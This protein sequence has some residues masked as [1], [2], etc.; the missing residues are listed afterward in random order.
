M[1]AVIIV[2]ILL[3]LYGLLLLVSA[4]F[5]KKQRGIIVSTNV[6][7]SVIVAFRNEGKH[8]ERLMKSLEKQV[9]SNLEIVLVDDHSED[10][11]CKVVKENMLSNVQLLHLPA[12]LTG[13]KQAI[14]YGVEHAKADYILITDADCLVPTSWVG[15]MVQELLTK[16]RDWQAGAIKYET[17]EGVLN[18]FQRIESAYL[19]MI[20]GWTMA[21]NKPTTCNGANIIFKKAV[22]EKE[23]GFEGLMQTPS[24]DDELLMQKL[25]S[26]GYKLGYCTSNAALVI[27]ASAESFSELINQRIRWASKMK[28]GFLNNNLFLALFILLVHIA[29]IASF[30]IDVSF[31]RSILMTRFFIEFFAALLMFL[32]FKMEFNLFYF[33]FSFFVYPLYV[34]FMSFASRLKK[35]K[36]KGR[37]Y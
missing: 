37:E 27:T 4:F 9:Y 31:G 17:K 26:K 29:V 36:W 24:G 25:F 8:L 22:F 5:W 11:S 14:A 23:K 13:K 32:T 34:I 1:E 16:K 28:Y 10:N 35:F 19:V 33:V 30:F 3:F 21:V 18:F 12:H 2:S 20:S 15:T 7:V 6:P